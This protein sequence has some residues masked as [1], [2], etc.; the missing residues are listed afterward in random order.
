MELNQAAFGRLSEILV[1]FEFP[2]GPIPAETAVSQGVIQETK[3]SQ[4]II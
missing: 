4:Y 1:N 3:K 2:G